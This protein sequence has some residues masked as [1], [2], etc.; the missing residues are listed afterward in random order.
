MKFLLSNR[1]LKELANGKLLRIAL[2]HPPHRIDDYKAW[3]RHHLDVPEGT[4]MSDPEIVQI[5][6]NPLDRPGGL[7]AVV[8]SLVSQDRIKPSHLTIEVECVVVEICATRTYRGRYPSQWPG[9]V[10][11]DDG[12][13]LP[14]VT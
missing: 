1:Q 10:I 4:L 3:V 8:G 2:P 12:T 5:T 13:A 7:A 11:L 9:R 6:V 14:A